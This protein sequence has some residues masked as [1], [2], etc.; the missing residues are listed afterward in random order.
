MT[1]KS[2]DLLAAGGVAEHD[3]CHDLQCLG[4]LTHR[5]RLCRCKDAAWKIAEAGGR[6]QPPNSTTGT[7]VAHG[8]TKLDSVEL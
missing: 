6:L 1:T 8:E 4:H 7:R 5:K 3:C 2:L